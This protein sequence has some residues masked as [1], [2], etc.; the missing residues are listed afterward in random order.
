MKTGRRHDSLIPLSREHHYGL[1]VCLRIHRGLETRQADLHW[2]NERA[3]KAINFFESDLK[4]HFEV[5][6]MVVFPAM[7]GIQEAAST[8]EDLV[9]D[10]RKLAKLIDRLGRE[11]GPKSALILREFADLLESHIRKEERNLFPL[12][13]HKVSP[14]TAGHVKD[15][16]LQLIGDAMRPKLPRLLE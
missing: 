4:T 2:L 9:D 11:R 14:E 15:Q 5:E 6:E 16:V 10:H 12:Y 3:E 13:E 1:L 8:I 7:N